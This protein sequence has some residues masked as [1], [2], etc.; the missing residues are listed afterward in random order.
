MCVAA[1]V[2]TTLLVLLS[3]LA[4]RIWINLLDRASLGCLTMSHCGLSL[5]GFV[6]SCWKPM[7]SSW[8]NSNSECGSLFMLLLKT[9]SKC[10]YILYH[11]ISTNVSVNLFMNCHNWTYEALY[12]RAAL[13]FLQRVSIACYSERCTSYSKSIRLSVCLSICLSHCHCVKMTQA[14]IMGSSL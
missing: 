11:F 12:F 7:Y 9:C 14:T 8:V 5:I 1:W 6:H 13:S 3:V 4:V 2:V 10:I